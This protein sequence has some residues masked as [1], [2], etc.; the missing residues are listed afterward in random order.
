MAKKPN[1]I[2]EP[3]EL[4]RVRERL[5]EVD[6]AEAKRMALVLGGEVGTEKSPIEQP[7]AKTAGR[8]RRETV[9][10]SIPGRERRT[11]S[12]SQEP[13]ARRLAEPDHSD[14]PNVQLVTPYLERV[15]MDRLASLPEFEIKSLRQVIAALFSH[16]KSG[17]DYVNPRFTTHRMTA[18]YDKMEQLVVSTRTLFPRNDVQRAE[19]VKRSSPYAFEILDTIRQWNIERIGGDLSKMQS[20][21]HKVRVSDYADILRLFYKPMFLLDKL[22]PSTH[23]KGAYELLY[24]IL[25]IDSAEKRE[26]VKELMQTAL[27]AYAYL[28]RSVHRGLHPLLMRFIS[29]RW[30]PYEKLFAARPRRF[31]AFLGVTEGERI[32]PQ[33]IDFERIEEE[34]QGRQREAAR[35]E[36][37]AAK[38]EVEAEAKATAAMTERKALDRSLSVLESLFP[39]AGWDRLDSYPDLYPYFVSIYGMRRGYEQIAPTD[40]VQQVAVL[41]H[42]IED[43]CSAF[44]FVSFEPVVGPDGSD[45]ILN[46]ELGKIAANWRGYIDGSFT[47][48]YL[49]RLT[50]YCNILAQTPGA[51]TSPYAKRILN[52]LHWAKRLYFLPFCKFESM[53]PPSFQRHEIRSI[54]SEV[55]VLRRYL[56]LVATAIEKWNRAGGPTTKLRCEALEAPLGR[57]NFNIANPV[58]KR[59][60]ILLPKS[61]RNN[62]HLIFFT[63]SAVTVLDFLLNS[64]SSWAYRNPHSTGYPYR[65]I[66]G[67]GGVPMFGVEEKIDADA[68]FRE[69]VMQARAERQAA[70]GAG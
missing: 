35:A 7:Q 34:N 25:P 4:D 23:I 46:D 68:I 6:V 55:K 13:Q 47:G 16:G 30:F 37:E 52:D 22:D 5:G 67:K 21:L 53:G 1:A 10:V 2:Y 8:L 70:K 11:A 20:R 38:A 63:L 65:T 45:I 36:D 54:Y 39:R 60:D 64:E 49:P 3:G 24:G 27:H 50:E 31:M 18:Y 40:P 51:S 33:E 58:S 17:S 61:R 62:M 28:R 42:I 66:E 29:D 57:Y 12:A 9:N 44:R 43:L 15:K 14:N 41:V 56:T 26:R 32:E 19:A 59:M 48:E 69:S